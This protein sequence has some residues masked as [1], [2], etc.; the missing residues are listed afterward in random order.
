MRAAPGT[1]DKDE[2]AHFSRDSGRW[3]DEHGPFA[4]LHRLN[5]VRLQFIKNEITGHFKCPDQGLKPFKDLKILDIGC[6]GGLVTEP[7]ARLGGTVTGIDADAQAIA[8]AKE[9]AAQADL[10]ISYRVGTAETLKQESYDVVLALEILEHVSDPQVF[11]QTC[12]HLSKP[13]GLIIFSTLNKTLK[14]KI[15]GIYAAEYLLGWV[16]KGTHS[17][18]KFIPPATLGRMMRKNGISLKSQKGLIFN[19]LTNCFDLSNKDFD[20]NYLISG[21]KL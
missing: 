9:H 18:N 16:P 15:L 17:W 20:I 19:P 1:A 10:K 6:G 5:P 3:W 11:V 8:V 13:G 7:M 14:S 4:P 12:A 2:I 21:E